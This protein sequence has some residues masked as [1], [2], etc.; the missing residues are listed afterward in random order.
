MLRHAEDIG[1]LVGPDFAITS[2]GDILE[3]AG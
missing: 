3:S 1:F 2:D